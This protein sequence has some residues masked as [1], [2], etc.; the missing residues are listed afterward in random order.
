[1]GFGEAGAQIIGQ[2]ISYN[3]DI[4]P[5]IP[6]DKSHSIFGFC[7]LDHF[8]ETTEALQEEVM[9]YVNKIAEI[10]HSMVDRFGGKANKNIGQ[11]FL[12]VWKFPNPD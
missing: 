10:T 8:I 9:S 6:G 5:I 7:S 4:N 3:G 1:M 2:N 12:L 11:A